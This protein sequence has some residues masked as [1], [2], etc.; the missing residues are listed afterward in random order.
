[1]RGVSHHTLDLPALPLRCPEKHVYGRLGLVPLRRLDSRSSP[2]RIARRRR[3]G[4][5]EHL[6]GAIQLSK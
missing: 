2:N 6:Q 4:S 3:A 1:M 5:V